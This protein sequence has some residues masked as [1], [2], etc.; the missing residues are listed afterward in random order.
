MKRSE[1]W[2]A[3]CGKAKPKLGSQRLSD[4]IRCRD[5]ALP[6]VLPSKEPK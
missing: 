4:G 5:C 6:K 2:C 1:F 3:K